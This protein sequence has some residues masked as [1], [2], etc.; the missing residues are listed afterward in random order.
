M[1]AIFFRTKLVGPFYIFLDLDIVSSTNT[2]L[3]SELYSKQI[4]PKNRKYKRLIKPN[5]WN[6]PNGAQYR[7]HAAKRFISRFF[8]VIRA[9][10]SSKKWVLTV[11][12][13]F[14]LLLNGVYTYF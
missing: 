11:I 14:F 4:G 10:F 3:I 2:N 8:G 1:Y 7:W 13:L 9:M 12:W 5:E 6:D